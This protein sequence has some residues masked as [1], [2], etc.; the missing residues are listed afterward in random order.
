MARIVGYLA[1]VRLVTRY[2]AEFVT[3]NEPTSSAIVMQPIQL[4]TSRISRVNLASSGPGPITHSD[5]YW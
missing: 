4:V 2:N 1:P 5:T 3:N